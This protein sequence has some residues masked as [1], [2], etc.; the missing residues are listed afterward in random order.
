[1]NERFTYSE[2][3][4]QIYPNLY[5][6][7]RSRKGANDAD[8]LVH[9]TMIYL[10]KN[11]AKY[12]F[13]EN[14]LALAIWKLKNIIIDRYRAESKK[15][16]MIEDKDISNDEG[17]FSDEE[18][19]EQKIRKLT[20]NAGMKKISEDCQEILNL[21]IAGNSY[22]AISSMLTIEVGTVGSRLV[23]CTE[24]LKEAVNAK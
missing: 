3:L 23:R 6:V 10:V 4:E 12:E 15:I 17:L 2:K 16:N 20:F 9:D 1:M 5:R 21:Q 14:I 11:K 8:D 19:E 22:E 13:H 24:S 18:T 7:A